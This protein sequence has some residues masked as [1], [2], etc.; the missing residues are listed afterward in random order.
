[1]APGGSR[2]RAVRSGRGRASDA[3]RAGV[4]AGSGSDPA[5]PGGTI[6]VGISVSQ[7]DTHTPCLSAHCSGAHTPL[8]PRALGTSCS[9]PTHPGPLGANCSGPTH[10]VL[11]AHHIVGPTH[12]VPQHGCKGPHPK[13][14]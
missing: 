14:A 3:G 7:S 1:V 8:T 6:S 10:T 9:G 4:G 12:P 11:S 13:K 5:V 2:S